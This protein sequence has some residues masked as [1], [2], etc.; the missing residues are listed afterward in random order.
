ML[1]KW[2]QVPGWAG[3][4]LGL[5]LAG[6][7][8]WLAPSSSPP[9]LEDFLTAGTLG[10]LWA[11]LVRPALLNGHGRWLLTGGLTLGLLMLLAPSENSAEQF[12]LML[13]GAGLGSI[14]AGGLPALWLRLP[15]HFRKPPGERRWALA[16]AAMQMRLGDD[17]RFH[18]LAAREEPFEARRILLE[19]WGIRDRQSCLEMLRWLE[20]EGHQAALSGLLAEDGAEGSLADFIAE[21]REALESKGI[22]AWDLGRLVQVVR[23]SVGAGYLGR[24]EGWERIA[25]AAGE[26]QAVHLSWEEYADHFMMGARYWSLL[27]GCEEPPFEPLRKW[28]LESPLSPWRKLPW[29]R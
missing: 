20:D 9:E 16:L 27:V 13:G 17:D 3:C 8:G 22:V 12:A 2:L 1:Q 24:A 25:S 10:A 4:F 23:W 15:D 7:C 6:A 14:L 29:P 18:H 5:A 26:L 21:H 11:T 19:G 28:L